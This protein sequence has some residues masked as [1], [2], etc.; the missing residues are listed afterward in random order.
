MFHRIAADLVIFLHFLW[1]A[2]L[3]MGFPVFLYLKLHKWR[4]V[5]LL[6]LIGTVVMQ[7]TG[8]ICPLT[9]LEVHLKSHGTADRVYPGQFIGEAVERLIYVENV[10]LDT[11][12]GITIVFLTAVLLSFRFRPIRFKKC[13]ATP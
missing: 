6:A 3:I 2:F 9:Y 10:T 1:I 7:V 12:T 13:D 4:I 8:G 11:V 5:H